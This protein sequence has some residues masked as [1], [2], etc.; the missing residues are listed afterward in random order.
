MR[1]QKIKW[2]L[3]RRVKDRVPTEKEPGIV[4]ALG[5]ADCA[6]VYIGETSRTAEQR[7]KEHQAHVKHGRTE[8]SAVAAH[9]CDLEHR[10]HWTPRIVKKKERNLKKRNIQEAL[11]INRL[12]KIGKTMNQDCGIDLSK[13]WLDLV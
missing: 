8:H 7:V 6:H 13:L 11:F 3:M 4:Y 2:S 12:V 1:P 5:C 9:A 10:I